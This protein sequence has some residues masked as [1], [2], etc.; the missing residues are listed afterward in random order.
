MGKA[1][2]AGNRRVA[3]KTSAQCRHSAAP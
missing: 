3:Q 1:F 2:Q